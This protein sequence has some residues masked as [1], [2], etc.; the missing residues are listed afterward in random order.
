MFR[1]SACTRRSFLYTTGLTIGGAIAGA[2]LSPA[3]VE[4]Q[5]LRVRPD[6]ASIKANDPL[7]DALKRGVAA[8]RALD[9]T[10]PTN[11]KGWTKLAKIHEDFCPHGNWFFLPWHRAYIYYFE[12]ICRD[13]SGYADFVLP[14]WDWSKSPKLPWQFWGAGN[15]LMDDRRSIGPND[16]ADQDSVGQ[17]VIYGGRGR[18][19]IINI[20]DFTDFAGW[21]PTRTPSGPLNQSELRYI[22]RERQVTGVLEQ[23][24]HNY[25]HSI[26]VRGN[27][28]ANSTSTLDPI[29]WLH[30]ANIDRLWTEWVWQNPN[31]MPKDT[32]QEWKFWYDFQ[33]MGFDNIR[34]PGQLTL[35]V[36]AV[37]S[38][39]ALGY[40]YDT[41][42]ADPLPLAL[43]KVY[44]SLSPALATIK[45]V[46]QTAT[47]TE[48]VTAESNV[49][50]ELRNHINR[51]RKSEGASYAVANAT[52]LRLTLEVEPPEDL[53]MVVRVFLNS[54]SANQNT[55]TGDPSYVGTFSFFGNDHA[56]HS[57]ASSR[58]IFD[59]TG[60]VRNLTSNGLFKDDGNVRVTLVP[61]AHDRASETKAS[62][63]LI[64]FRLEA[65]P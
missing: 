2:N 21:P 6:I 10:D 17:D 39:H 52:R 51:F 31:Q 54:P 22:L 24:P 61:V 48:A 55:P 23:T 59:V 45:V 64:S 35:S 65:V 26:F 7:L 44:P 15:P 49:S 43:A 3:P 32:T 60:T 25:I 37:L 12:Q 53:R 4:S 47:T 36:R 14:Y 38:T 56:E 1:Q 27:M 42:P 33:L 29:F 20:P 13:A 40:R 28:S 9:N 11:P 50:A 5:T 16:N 18:Q 63:H 62:V 19:G 46:G 41:Q 8:L 58:F 34:K 30:H 57:G